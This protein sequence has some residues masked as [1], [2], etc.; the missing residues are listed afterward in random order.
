MHRALPNADKPMASQPRSELLLRPQ[1]VG[2]GPSR[3]IRATTRTGAAETQPR[4]PS[5]LRSQRG[6]ASSSIG[7]GASAAASSLSHD[8]ERE[9]TGPR[10]SSSIGASGAAGANESP[11]SHDVG[12]PASSSTSTAPHWPLSTDPIALFYGVSLTLCVF[13]LSKFLRKTCGSGSIGGN[14]TI[15]DE[16]DSI[17]INTQQEYNDGGATSTFPKEEV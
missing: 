6:P 5:L 4:S 10:S 1:Q 14:M 2:A 3:S 9:A 12:V 11:L 13:F 16:T 17:F 7:I 8:A 15:R